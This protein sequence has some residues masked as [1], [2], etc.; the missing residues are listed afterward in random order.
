MS[1]YV[2]LNLQFTSIYREMSSKLLL[3]N[4]WK[5]RTTW[6]GQCLSSILYVASYMSPFFVSAHIEGYMLLCIRQYML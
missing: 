1:R 4:K 6:R 5:R 3:K 2:V